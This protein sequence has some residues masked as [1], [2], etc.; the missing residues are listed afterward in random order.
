MGFEASEV[1]SPII[2]AELLTSSSGYSSCVGTIRPSS[3]NCFTKSEVITLVAE[4]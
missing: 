2:K 3:G 4:G 1:H